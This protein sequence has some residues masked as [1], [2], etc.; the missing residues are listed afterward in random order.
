MDNQIAEK[1]EILKCPKDSVNNALKFTASLTLVTC[2]EIRDI[3]NFLVEKGIIKEEEN[4]CLLSPKAFKILP[5]GLAFIE[6]RVAEMEEIGELDCYREDPSRINILDANL[7]LLY[8]KNNG[9]EYR[10][11]KGKYLPIIFDKVEFIKKYGDVDLALAGSMEDNAAIIDFNVDQMDDVPVEE[12]KEE[13]PAEPEEQ[14]VEETTPALEDVQEEMS[15]EIGEITLDAAFAAEVSAETD[16]SSEIPEVPSVEDIGITTDNEDTTEEV[17]TGS[18]V[19]DFD[20]TETI[21]A[22]ESGTTSEDV[23]TTDTTSTE[24]VVEDETGNMININPDLISTKVLENQERYQRLSIVLAN[25]YAGIFNIEEVPSE[26]LQYLNKFIEETT[27]DDE[28]L[29][30][31]LLTAGSAYSDEDKAVILDEI[32]KQVA[33]YGPVRMVA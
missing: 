15:E 13:T 3:V 10:N 16:T 9:I 24:E 12:S 19:V 29:L 4:K 18:E 33:A 17:A 8:L 32:K 31:Q 20:A 11:A 5:R 6:G 26:M 25:L 22:V 1:L 30:F 21:D 28:A 2:E 7:R 14:A 27:Y 23:D